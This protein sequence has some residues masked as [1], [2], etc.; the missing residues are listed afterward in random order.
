MRS[1]FSRF[2]PRRKSMK[3]KGILTRTE[4]ESFRSE[5]FQRVEREELLLKDAA[6]ILELSYSQAKRLFARFKQ[7]GPQGLAH[8]LRGKP[9]NRAFDPDIK[10]TILKLYRDC[11]PDFGPTL[12]AEKLQLSGYKLDHETLRLWLIEEGLWEKHRKR[13]EHR[14]W[15]ERRAHFGELVQM[16]GSFHH[17]FESRGPQTCLMNMVDDATSATLSLM[18][19]EETTQAAMTLLWKWIETFGIPAALYTDRKNVYVVD[20]KSALRA[21]LAGEERLTQFGRACKKLG[22][23]IITAHS[24]QAKGRVERSNQTYQDRLVKELRL[25]AISDISSANEFLY[26]GYLEELNSKFAVEPREEEDFHRK[27]EGVDLASILCIEEERS[28]S[29]DWIVRFDNGFYQLKRQSKYEPAKGKVF[30]RKYL[31]SDLHFNYRGEDLPYEKLAER[32][33]RIVKSLKPKE[34]KRKYKPSPDHPWRKSWK[35]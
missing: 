4:I 8:Y 15:R 24:P 10:Q 29:R 20:E 30:V 16:D 19:E 7:D 21:S 25:A 5:T 33:V 9:S 12:A 23:I 3:K 35:H 18:S 17:W 31:N 32:P 11:Y 22:I 28:I 1:F 13:S 27:A 14:S 34:E 26:G 2:L 6:L